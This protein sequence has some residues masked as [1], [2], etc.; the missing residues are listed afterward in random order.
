M[1]K[2][3][4]LTLAII[5]SC[6]YPLHAQE[7]GRFNSNGDYP[8]IGLYRG[9]LRAAYLQWQV[10][11][12]TL[13]LQSVGAVQ[14]FAGDKCA[15][16]IDPLRNT[17]IFGNLQ[18]DGQIYSG[19]AAYNERTVVVLEGHSI[20]EHCQALVNPVGSYVVYEE[21]VGG[22]QLKQ[23]AIRAR[24][25]V[26]KH[27]SWAAGYNVCVL[28]G[29][30]NSIND[31]VTA[32]DAFRSIRAFVRERE[33]VGFDT[34]V[35]HMLSRTGLDAQKTAL[36]ALI[37]EEFPANRVITWPVELEGDGASV[38][39]ATFTDGIHLTVPARVMMAEIISDKI[40]S[41]THND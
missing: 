7:E 36:N 33:K 11:G 1:I 15:V 21:A 12:N 19:A 14:V 32:Q 3:I 6:L 23:I 20:M 2:K 40:E 17:R 41:I 27:Y 9:S 5:T 25:S 39:T 28:L 38:N 18:V 8:F 30:T 10:N 35:C 26:D 34:V 4:I 29:A 31:G 37:D 24:N 13:R 22:S 16:H